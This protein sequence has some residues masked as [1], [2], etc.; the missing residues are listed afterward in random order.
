MFATEARLATAGAGFP[1]ASVYSLSRRGWFPGGSS[2]PLGRGR[3]SPVKV[4]QFCSSKGEVSSV[5]RAK[6]VRAL[7]TEYPYNKEYHKVILHSKARIRDLLGGRNPG[8]E[9]HLLGEKGQGTE[10]KAGLL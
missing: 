6:S 4:Y 5:K 2:A 9:P 8:G 1:A 10:Q 7:L 3:V